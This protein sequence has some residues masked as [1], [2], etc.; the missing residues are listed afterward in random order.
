M[1]K[2]SFNCPSCNQKFEYDEDM[3]GL[4]TCCPNLDCDQ[5]LDIPNGPP[6]SPSAADS[7]TGPDTEPTVESTGES[8]LLETDSANG[9]PSETEYI[10]ANDTQFRA[11]DDPDSDA[12]IA[13]E[14]ELDALAPKP[15]KSK[16]FTMPPPKV[17]ALA[18]LLLAVLGVVAKSLMPS[19]PPA[20]APA[21]ETA[22]AAGKA[23]AA[24]ATK[25]SDTP[26]TASNANGAVTTTTNETA[27]SVTETAA[28]SSPTGVSPTNPETN[29]PPVVAATKS[30][31][32]TTAIKPP[33][34][35][36]TV[37]NEPA[38]VVEPPKPKREY[39]FFSIR[40]ISGSKERPIVMLN[41]GSNNYNVME[42][43]KLDIKTPEGKMTI[44]CVSIE[45]RI[46]K[47]LVDDDEE[48]TKVYA[49]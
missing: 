40:A 38:A 46:V 41:T 22:D 26:E 6:G 32:T 8:A 21:S 24:D 34:T 36:S 7:P 5:I 43:D 17:I 31:A 12:A 2:F 20:P 27:E 33:A 9:A 18:V 44:K 15:E 37:T 10:H 3:F 28:K 1:E 39:K 11:A 29:A 23:D 14:A 16:K 25:K 35:T 13:S 45:N 49:P 19:S 48:P 30:P 4:Q 47:L 42:G